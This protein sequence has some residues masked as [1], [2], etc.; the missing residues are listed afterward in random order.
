MTAPDKLTV[1]QCDRDAVEAWRRDF[2][3]K[4]SYQDLLQAFARHRQQAEARAEGL[5][6]ALLQ[7]RGNL[8]RALASAMEMSEET[9]A[10][11][12]SVKD[13]DDALTAYRSRT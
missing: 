12:P 5:E 6:R 13:I 8:V 2:G 7:A 1:E 11:M 4:A 10:K 9:V 3:R